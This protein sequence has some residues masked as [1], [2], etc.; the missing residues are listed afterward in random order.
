MLIGKVLMKHK[1]S[2]WKVA[3]PIAKSLVELH[4]GT[5]TVKS[6]P[7]EGTMFTVAL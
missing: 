5:I 4:G 1:P 3:L 7:G 2:N 6:S